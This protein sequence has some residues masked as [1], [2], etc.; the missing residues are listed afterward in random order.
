MVKAKTEAPRRGRPPGVKN[1]TK[2][3]VKTPLD[4]LKSEY[5]SYQRDS[6][7]AVNALNM[8]VKELE[9][10]IIGYQA[11]ISYLE[12]QLGLKRSM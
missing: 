4:K 7:T 1:K 3:Q 2:R 9:H 8:R 10:E 12:N 6:N 11:V 5:L